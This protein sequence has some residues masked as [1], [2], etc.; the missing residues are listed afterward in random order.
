MAYEMTVDRRTAL[1]AAGLAGLGLGLSACGRGFGG[2]DDDGPS[3]G[4]VS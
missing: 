4:K 3:G 1:K 2:G